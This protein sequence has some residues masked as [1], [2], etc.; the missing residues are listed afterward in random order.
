VLYLTVLFGNKKK[1]VVYYLVGFETN[2]FSVEHIRHFEN[3]INC[4]RILVGTAEMRL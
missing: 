3:I 2:I 4:H 1:Y